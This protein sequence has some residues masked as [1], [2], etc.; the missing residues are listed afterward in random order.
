MRT[1]KIISTLTEHPKLTTLPVNDKTF[2]S[3]STSGV[4]LRDINT[5]KTLRD[6]TEI[7]TN[8]IK[9]IQEIGEVKA[10]AISPDSTTVAIG[11]E[12]GSLQLWN[13]HTENRPQL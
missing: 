10:F 7:W 13:M 1:S 9:Y 4:Q 3:L 12:D 8:L 5:G 2:I 11:S 6:L